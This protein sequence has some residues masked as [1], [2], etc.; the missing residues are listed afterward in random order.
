[1]TKGFWPNFWIG[2]CYGSIFAAIVVG[3]ITL[4]VYLR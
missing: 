2:V 1:M 4:G 3:A